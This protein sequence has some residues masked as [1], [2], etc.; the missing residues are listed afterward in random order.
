[1]R[2]FVEVLGAGNDDA[3]AGLLLFFDDARYLFE[4]GDGTQRYCTER[5]V[6]LGRLRSICLTSLAAPSIGGL[7]GMVLTIADAGKEC[8]T[9][10]GPKGVSAL[11]G[12]ARRSAFCFRP[13]METRLVDILASRPAAVSGSSPKHAPAHVVCDDENLAIRAV[14]IAADC[15]HAAPAVLSYVCRLRDIAGKFNPKRAIELGVPTGPLFGQ[16]K[17]GDAVTLP[18]GTVVRPE[19]VVSRSVPGPVIAVVACPSERHIAAVVSNPELCPVQLGIVEEDGSAADSAPVCVIYHRSPRSVL[20]H[21]DYQAWFRRFGAGTSHVTL[22]STLAP[23]RIVFASQAKD[24][25]MLHRFDAD[26]FKAPWQSVRE[27]ERCGEPLDL[28]PQHAG[29]PEEFIAAKCGPVGAQWHVGD[30]GQQFLLAPVAS[31]GFSQNSVPPR[32]VSLPNTV[33]KAE[34]G[35]WR[36][37]AEAEEMRAGEAEFPEPACVS[38]FSRETAELCFLGTAG[39][40][41]GKHRNVS[42]IYLHMFGRGGVVLDCG[43]GTW[44]QITRCYGIERAREILR[45][46]SVVF[47]SH[48]HA[49]HHLGLLSLLHER[50]VAL[51]AANERDSAR[52]V[53]VGPS[54]LGLWL[55]EYR[56]ILYGERAP[57]ATYRFCDARS[58]AEPQSSESN[59]LAESHGLNVSCVEVIHCPNSFGVVIGDRVREWSVVYSGDTRPCQALADAGKKATLAI[60]E[61]TLDDSMAQEAIDKNHCTT[62][63]ALTVCGEWMGAWRTILTH[64]SQRYPRVP[65]LDE[66]TMEGLRR[67]RASIA[68]D[69]MR[70]NFADLVQIPQTMPAI[71]EAFS[72]ELR[73][74]LAKA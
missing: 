27:T 73:I 23:D 28:K 10:A 7:M 9:I 25:D 12:A 18:D 14:P 40:I 51:E 64:F 6:R 29:S 49:D 61:A 8:V 5:S 57:L 45:G 70:V 16:L 69:L 74:A 54:Q 46:L 13:A 43:E 56:K 31:A 65:L 22:H 66:E 58:L 33:A 71:R 47:I 34:S 68:F 4:C 24:L 1:M 20:A 52:L 35:L 59:F 48:I 72:A 19:S 42:G 30:C 55:G 53:I 36:S 2:A 41:P 38:R 37:Y 44:G 39:A 21:P 32:F 50:D 62:S 26:R 15:D 67:N 60:H 3:A 11:F 63:E 17:K